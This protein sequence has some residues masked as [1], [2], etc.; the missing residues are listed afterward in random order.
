MA[1]FDKYLFNNEKPKS[2]V[3]KED[4][5]LSWLLKK[6]QAKQTTSVTTH[7]SSPERPSAS[8]IFPIATHAAI[9]SA[10][11]ITCPH[12]QLLIHETAASRRGILPSRV[13]RVKSRAAGTS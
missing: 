2:L 5:P 4:S 10:S 11:S 6:K 1:W 12:P 7:Q 13:G 3:V 8:A 9:A